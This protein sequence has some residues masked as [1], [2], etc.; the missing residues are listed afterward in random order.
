MALQSLGTSKLMYFQKI[1]SD[2]DYYNNAHLNH[3]RY[4]HI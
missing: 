4:M 1:K 2:L 3:Y